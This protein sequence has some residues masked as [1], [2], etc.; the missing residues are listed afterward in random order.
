MFEWKQPIG[1]KVINWRPLK[2]GDHID[3]DANYSRADVA[4]MKRFVTLAAR[5]LKVGDK[6]KREFAGDLADLRDWDEYD[7][8]AFSDEVESRELARSVALAP[9]RQ[10]GAVA[11]L[12]QA[13][14]KAQAALTESARALQE[15]VQKAKEAEQKLGPLP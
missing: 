1:G 2:V 15:V 5:I 7:L 11:S 8:I 9:Q 14:A 10:G 4:H 3:I 13:V 6:E 12:E